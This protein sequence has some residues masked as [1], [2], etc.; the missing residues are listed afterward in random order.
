MKQGMTADEADAIINETLYGNNKEIDA[1]AESLTKTLEEAG[2]NILAPGTK[3]NRIANELRRAN[4]V[5]NGT[6][7]QSVIEDLIAKRVI[8]EKAR[9]IKIDENVFNGILNAAEATAGKGLGHA[10]D[11]K[12][13]REMFDKPSQRQSKKLSEARKEGN[14]N[15]IAG[16]LAVNTGG[17]L[18]SRFVGGAARWSW[19]SFQKVSGLALAQTI[20][21]D[22]V[23]TPE[24]MTKDGKL[25]FNKNLIGRYLNFKKLSD[26]FDLE[27]KDGKPVREDGKSQAEYDIE[28]YL[29]LRER[30]KREIIGPL[31]GYTLASAVLPI[32]A[33]MLGFGYDDDDS[34]E[35][36]ADKVSRLMFWLSKPEQRDIRN[37]INK[38]GFIQLMAYMGTIA[39]KDKYGQ[40]FYID[41]KEK[42][43]DILKTAYNLNVLNSIFLENF[44]KGGSF[45][46]L[47][48]LDEANRNQ[49]G[50]PGKVLVRY[51]TE[52]SNIGAPFKFWD[53]NKGAING[54]MQGKTEGQPKAETLKDQFLKSAITRDM[55]RSYME[56]KD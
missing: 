23:F 35:K 27:Y 30:L 20:L 2:L 1:L 34:D 15:K 43:N 19:L 51:G 21:T 22:I 12:L 33:K 9:D 14:R 50:S 17:S 29:S 10:S 49:D 37:I 53:M 26:N 56:K 44:N 45:N 6:F 32:L 41:P 36:K 47:K 38:V 11:N 48:D 31:V 4:I 55:F 39:K 7:F 18:L 52:L 40:P 8:S 25:A 3:T 54:I 42:D 16:Q 5:S 46:I 24:V 28:T 13:F